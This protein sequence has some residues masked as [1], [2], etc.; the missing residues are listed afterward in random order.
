[1]GSLGRDSERRD[2][3]NLYF[4]SVF[5]SRTFFDPS[6]IAVLRVTQV[7]LWETEATDAGMEHVK[8]ITTLSRLCLDGTKVT[9]AGLTHLKGVES[10]RILNLANTNVTDAGLEHLEGLKNLVE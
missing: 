7:G 2:A 3:G 6:P 8:G 5:G 10:L 1:M 4:T 9:D